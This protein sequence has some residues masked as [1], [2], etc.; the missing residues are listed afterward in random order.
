MSGIRIVTDSAC[1]LPPATASEHNIEIVPLTVRIGDTEYVDRRDL[2]PDEFWAKSSGAKQLPETAA[3]SPGAFEQAFRDAASKGATGVV[4]V[5][6]SSGLSAT[7]QSAQ[8]AADAVK[9]S[10]PVRVIDSRS[11]T[12]AQGLLAIAGAEAAAAGKSID[13]VA[14]V[15]EA[16]IP[17][18]RVFAALDTLENLKKGGRIG[19]A[20][21]A[22]GSMLNIKPLIRVE[23]GA[24]EEAGKQRTRSRSLDQLIEIAKEHGAATAKPLAVMHGNAPDVDSFVDSLCGALGRSREDIL[25]GDIGSVV[26]THAGPRVIGIAYDESAT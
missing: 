6:L 23:N 26:G 10:I 14:S 8:L 21:A 3:P 22:L 19:A 4:C 11:V 7:Y 16:K 13:E 9:D 17:R 20:R 5:T 25:I 2:T 1:D 15:I 24:V 18:M 12:I